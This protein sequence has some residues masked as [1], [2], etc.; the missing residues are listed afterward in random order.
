MAKAQDTER[1]SQDDIADEAA[2]QAELEAAVTPA[3][4]ERPAAEVA[5][6][7]AEL[8]RQKAL[9]DAVAGAHAD[10]LPKLGGPIL[11]PG[12]GR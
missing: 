1:T 4:A 10:E 12:L 8:D 3:P 9:A 6:E 5:A 2:R 11:E 7:R